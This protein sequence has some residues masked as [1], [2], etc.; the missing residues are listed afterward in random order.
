MSLYR[1]HGS[2]V[3]VV[4]V[5]CGEALDDCRRQHAQTL[6]CV[7]SVVS[8]VTLRCGVESSVVIVAKKGT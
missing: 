1:P 6:L 7:I 8:L 5:V 4:V 2:L 3:L